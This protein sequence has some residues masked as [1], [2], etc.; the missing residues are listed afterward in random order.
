MTSPSASLLL[1]TPRNENNNSDHSETPVGDRDNR[2]KIQLCIE[3]L[4]KKDEKRKRNTLKTPNGQNP[5]SFK[6]INVTISNLKNIPK[7]PETKKGKGSNPNPFVK[8]RC[9]PE[10][11]WNHEIYTTELLPPKRGQVQYF[12]TFQIPITSDAADDL[13]GRSLEV[14]VCDRKVTRNAKSLGSVKISLENLKLGCP[15]VNWYNLD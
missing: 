15:Q 9:L 12:E 2:L 13:E 14:Q 3:Y 6:Q 8:I 4:L 7:P 11:S 1:Q 5:A 10:F